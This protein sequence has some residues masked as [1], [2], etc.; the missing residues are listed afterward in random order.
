MY[1]KNDYLSPAA[2]TPRRR[3]NFSTSHPSNMEPKDPSRLYAPTK[4]DPD[5]DGLYPPQSQ[6][7]SLAYTKLGSDR[8]SNPSY[9]AMGASGASTFMRFFPSVFK[10][11]LFVV[12]GV[13]SALYIL[14]QK[15]L[16]PRPLSA[17]V[18]KVLFWPTFPITYSRR[19]GKWMTDIDDTVVMG[20]APIHLLNYP[21]ILRRDYGVKGVINLCQEYR[22][23]I[24]EYKR[25]HIEELY[26]PT[27]DH[28]EPSVE[29]LIKAVYFIR[30]IQ[31]RG[32]GKVYVHC[33]AGHGRSA[34]VVYAWL[35]ANMEDPENVDMVALNSY[36]LTLRDVRKTLW[37]QANINEF[38]EW[39]VLKQN[40][41]K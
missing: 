2:S 23:P 30:K 40:E 6:R 31:K 35:L 11:T 34:A 37:K 5:D 12:F 8:Y 17:V 15:H 36:L 41:N 4:V 24:K 1:E 21:E 27:T 18:S 38:K 29:D 13:A 9:S 14:N 19:L 7:R 25:L 39:L 20:G 28:F 32:K 10:T 33:K 16:L 3:N 22:G 26:L